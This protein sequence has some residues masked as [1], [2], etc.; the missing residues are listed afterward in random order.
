MKKNM[1]I[2]DRLTRTTIAVAVGLLYLADQITG[3]AAV[4]L[5]VLSVIF[6]ATSIVGFCPVYKLIGIS[7]LKDEESGAGHPGGAAHKGV[8]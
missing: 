7:T 1:G 2:I 4:I 3:T 5:G 6:V 8:H